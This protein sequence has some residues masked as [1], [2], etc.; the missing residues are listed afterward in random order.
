MDLQKQEIYKKSINNLLRGELKGI[1]DIGR[2]NNPYL[3]NKKGVSN[4]FI[5]NTIADFMI[6]NV[7]TIKGKYSNFVSYILNEK[8]T[9]TFLLTNNDPAST[10]KAIKITNMFIDDIYV[11]TYLESLINSNFDLSYYIGTE[12]IASKEYGQRNLVNGLFERISKRSLWSEKPT[13]KL[14][15]YLFSED[16]M[17]MGC[18]RDIFLYFHN[19]DKITRKWLINRTDFIANII[20]KEW[21]NELIERENDKQLVK[22]M[23]ENVEWDDNID[24]DIFV[25]FYLKLPEEDKKFLFKTEKDFFEWYVEKM[26]QDQSTFNTLFSDWTERNEVFFEKLFTYAPDLLNRVS[27][28]IDEDELVKL[29]Y[30]DDYEIPDSIKEQIQL[31]MSESVI[32]DGDQVEKL[33]ADYDSA[34]SVWVKYFVDQTLWEHTLD[35]DYDDVS[36]PFDEINEKNLTAIKDYLKNKGVEVDGMD[37]DELEEAM[38]EDDKLYSIISM[39]SSDGHRAGDENELYRD[40]ES[41]MDELFPN[42]WELVSKGIQTNISLSNFD[43]EIIIDAHYNCSEWNIKCLWMEIMSEKSNR[44]KPSLPEYRYG[45]NGEFSTSTFNEVIAEGLSNLE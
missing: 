38:K 29:K 37:G 30:S 41:V 11:N 21:V 33:V 5:A 9:I 16:G 32:F 8:D 36:I 14:L 34:P 13:K 22:E 35:W 39:A 43:G 31:I 7:E 17:I 19:M 44:D 26:V 28:L 20:P 6:N 25:N 3:L 1:Y 24:D 4:F 23:I 18:R 2:S 15:F 42:G 45:I 12:N 10:E 40:I 27:G